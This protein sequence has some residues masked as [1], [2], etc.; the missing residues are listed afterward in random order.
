LGANTLRT[1]SLTGLS[2]DVDLY[3]FD[4][5]ASLVPACVSE[6]SR[7]SDEDC[8]ATADGT[9]TLWVVVD[10]SF[11]SYGATYSLEAQ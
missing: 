10:G 3:V 5:A 9:G 11:S 7:S 4:A 8:A 1:V 6:R 2:D